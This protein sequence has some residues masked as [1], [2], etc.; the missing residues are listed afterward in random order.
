MS[1]N[2]DGKAPE[3]RSRL[4]ARLRE[5]R[6]SK[7]LTLSVVSE[8]TGV[9]TSSLSKIE[10]EQVSVSYYTL[11]KICD[12]LDIP[13]EE[14]INPEHKSY[15]SGRRSITRAGEGAEFDCRQYLY[16][17][18]S[19]DLSRKDMIP[20]E[21]TIL[22]RQPEDFDD[23][24]KHEGEEFVYVLS[25]EIQVCTEFYAPVR[26]KAGDSMYF[27]SSMGHKYISVSVENARIL[28]ICYDPRA[29]QQ[30]GVLDFFRAGRLMVNPREE[31]AK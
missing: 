11:K 12:G 18:H 21:M 19:T 24:N 10:N 31:G 22:A 27:D 5:W 2:A 1:T 9:A 6:Q 3:P 15:A 26:L 23:W 25:G 4:G 14:I 29:H 17:A 30:Q 13:I 20:L 8:R 7:G 16:V 28:S